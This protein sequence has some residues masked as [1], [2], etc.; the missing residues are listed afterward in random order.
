MPRG[1]KGRPG[2]PRRRTQMR[3]RRARSLSWGP[4]YFFEHPEGV[5]RRWSPENTDVRFTQ[6]KRR[7]GGRGAPGGLPKSS[8]KKKYRPM[9]ASR[10]AKRCSG[11]AL[12]A[13]KTRP[14]CPERLQE[15]SKTRP[16]GLHFFSGG[17]KMLQMRLGPHLGSILNHF[18]SIF[19]SFLD[20]CLGDVSQFFSE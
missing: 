2:T 17:S 3:P 14:G 8:K 10:G 11:T 15:A 9:T 18:W 1:T 13:P 7:V 4:R 20:S 6:V 19:K 5:K 16:K 12:D